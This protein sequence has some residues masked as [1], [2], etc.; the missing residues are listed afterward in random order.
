MVMLDDY[1]LR[2]FGYTEGAP[3]VRVP[4]AHPAYVELERELAK[5]VAGVRDDGWVYLYTI[6]EWR[7]VA[8]KQRAQTGRG[9]AVGANAR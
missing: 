4:T 5:P 8:A 7:R 2:L 3:H 1:D 6:Q 9:H